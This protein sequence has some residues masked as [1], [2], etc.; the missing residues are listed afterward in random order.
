MKT[1]P[2]YKYI[3]QEWHQLEHE[4]VFAAHWIFLGLKTELAGLRY[5][6]VMIGNVGIIL[7]LDAR[8]VP[9]AFRNV[10]SHRSSRLC[11]LGVH[12]GIIRC[13]YH[14]WSYD[15]QGIPINVPSMSAF[16]QVISNP[17][18][19]R[20]EEYPCEAAGQFIFAKLKRQGPSL[21]DY[22]GNQYDFIVSAS[23]GFS[24]LT[25]IFEET[26]DANW[27]VAVENALE[28]YHVPLVH[29]R[30]FME[31]DGMDNRSTAPVFDVTDNLHS[32]LQ[33]AANEDWIR[34]FARIERQIGTWPGRFEGYTHR[35]IFP[36]LTVTSFMGYSYHI[37]VF[38][39]ERVGSTRVVSRT[40][41]VKFKE[42]SEV[43]QR[44]IKKIYEDGHEF[45]RRVFKED[46]EI[47]KEVQF[48]LEQ[49]PKIVAFG[50]GIEDRV[51]HFHHAYMS[52]L[53]S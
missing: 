38:N 28:G 48:G 26:L 31:V 22:L 9:R 33:H 21:Q 25:D 11:D 30:T 53:Q 24:S 41:G 52:L 3:S 12:E 35:L 7:Q 40:M 42:S 1:I 20:L 23:E 51:K 6:G 17:S 29:S 16:P 8:G 13:P 18:D 45:T 49:S 27:K 4:R 39:P 46:A 37:Q 47:C 19:Y 36:N 32:S 2:A 14:G 44:M 15:R 10:C 43:G 34:R 50:Q 5:L